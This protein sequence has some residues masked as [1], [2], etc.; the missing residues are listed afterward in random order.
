MKS[1]LFS[2]LSLVLLP[3]FGNGQLLKLPANGNSPKGAVSEVIGITNI[4]VNYSRPGVKKRDGKVWG[5]IVKWGFGN[6]S[7]MGYGN[8]SP[9][10]APWRAGANEN[11]SIEFEHDMFIEEKPIKAGK[12]GLHMAVWPDSCLVILTSVNTAWGS[13]YYEPKNDV[14]RVVVKPVA[15]NEFEE[16]LRF[17]FSEQTD[18]SA[19]LSLI[20]EKLKIPIKLRVN[21]PETVIKSMRE[22]LIGPD[23]FVYPAWT[24]ASEWCLRY[25]LNL[26]EALLWS[27]RGISGFGGQPTFRSYVAKTNIL[28]K[29][30]RNK[31]S[32]SVALKAIEYGDA[33]QINSVARSFLNKKDLKTTREIVLYNEKKHGD[34]FAVNTGYM[35]LLS[36]EGDYNKAIS[37][38]E[39]ALAQSPNETSKKGIE[40]AIKKLKEGKDINQ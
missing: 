19:V 24:L 5:G 34:I 14:L 18:S 23:G 40:D 30:G 35:R 9:T 7:F 16:R 1:N 37:Y 31:A 3:I 28:N 21:V 32:D 2:Y 22:Q 20:W 17:D 29:L 25:N 38:A 33:N 36:A 10:G 6:S 13:F 27:D 8:F 15:I 11:T 4:S 12:Y 39:K 26:E